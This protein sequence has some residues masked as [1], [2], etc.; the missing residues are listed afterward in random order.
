MGFIEPSIEYTYLLED[1]FPNIFRPVRRERS[2][3][4]SLAFDVIKNQLLVHPDT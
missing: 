1:L 3:Q 4:K 2:E